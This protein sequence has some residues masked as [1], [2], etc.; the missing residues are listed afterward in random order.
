MLVTLPSADRLA[1]TRPRAAAA[2]KTKFVATPLWD[3][4][5]DDKRYGSGE[6]EPR[7]ENP[8]G[9]SSH[10]CY[11]PFIIAG[12]TLPSFCPA[13]SAANDKT[14]FADAVAVWHMADLRFGRRQQ[15]LEGRRPGQIGHRIV[16][17]NSIVRDENVALTNGMA[18]RM[19]S[20]PNEGSS[21]VCFKA[22]R[23]VGLNVLLLDRL[24]HRPGER[25]VRAMGLHHRPD[26]RAQEPRS[27]HHHRFVHLTNITQGGTMDGRMIIGDSGG[28]GGSVELPRQPVF[29]R[30]VAGR[31]SPPSLHTTW[32]LGP[33]LAVRRR[34]ASCL[35][36][37][38]IVAATALRLASG[39]DGWLDDAGTLL[40]Q[41]TRSIAP[42]T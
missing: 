29:L 27:G 13:T 40:L 24:L 28:T 33:D 31:V 21:R 39:S 38:P 8:N 41:S 11:T 20:A 36:K 7:R 10:A 19:S 22:L 18:G 3:S 23:L 35:I 34:G 12:L 30:A 37:S 25:V 1:W 2:A 6:S 16:C 32:H 14:P 42:R 5:G 4:G 15:R 9:S 26:G 17:M